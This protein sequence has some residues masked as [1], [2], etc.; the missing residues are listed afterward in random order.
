MSATLDLAK[1]YKRDVLTRERADASQLVDY[2]GSIYR[3]LKASLSELNLEI[4]SAKLQG[5]EISPGWLYQRYRF[6]S[7]LAQ[8]EEQV[9]KFSFAL[10]RGVR[11]SQSALGA[12]AV[13]HAE[14]LTL[15]GL[16]GKLQASFTRLPVG[17]IEE[18]VGNLHDGT[19]LRKL[20]D[21]LGSE[22]SAKVRHALVSG[23]ALGHGPRKLASGMRD[24]LGGS[25]T[26]A[27]LISRQETL[28]AYRESSRRTYEANAELLQG[29]M[30]LSARSARTC[31]ACWA[32]DGKIFPVTTPMASHISCRCT[33]VPITIG[34]SV[35]FGKGSDLFAGLSEEEQREVLG[36]GGFEAYKAGAKLDDFVKVKRSRTW[37]DAYVTRPLSEV[38]KRQG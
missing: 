36:D 28:R 7:L 4:E 18:L 16:D 25:L 34:S 37:G 31:A 27:L 20:L 10:E 15:T 13:S 11:D 3:Q 26:R 6:L 5:E 35:S 38:V 24:A 14:A 19:P 32:Q 8:V 1:S 30:W 29:W 2:Y 12:L 22:A 17:A 23:V 9:G 33:M 21:E